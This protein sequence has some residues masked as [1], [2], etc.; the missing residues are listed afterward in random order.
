M[1]KTSANAHT[2]Y[3]GRVF[4]LLTVM[5]LPL[6][7]LTVF[8]ACENEKPVQTDDTS[9]INEAVP[10]TPIYTIVRPDRDNDEEIAAA[11]RLKKALREEYGIE[12]ELTTDWVKRG[13]DIEANRYPHE[14]T[15]GETNRAESIS[16][17]DALKRGTPEMADYSIT[18]NADHYTIAASAGYLDDAV[19]QFLSYIKEN[20]ALLSQEPAVLNDLRIHVFPLSDIIIAGRSVS[21]YQAIVYPDT[22]NSCQTADV[23]AVSDLIFDSCGIRIPVLKNKDAANVG[24]PVIRI[25][26]RSDTEVL[27]AGRFSY[28]LSVTEDGI[29]IDGRDAWG[30]SRGITAFSDMLSDGQIQGGTLSIGTENSIR[31]LNPANDAFLPIAA[32]VISA[33]DMT[34]EEQFAEIKDCGFNMVIL[35]RTGDEDLFHKHCKWL[36]KYELTVLWL[37]YSALVYDSEDPVNGA[38]YIRLDKDNAYLN[39]DIT[40][41]TML[42]DEP[43]ASL[44]GTLK[45]AYDA[46][47][48][49][50]EDKIPYINLFPSYATNEQL[51]SPSYEDH[52]NT[53]LNTVKPAFASVDIYPLNTGGSINGDYFYNLDVF[54]TACRTRGIPFSVYIQSVSFAS[55]KRTPDE[56][57]MLWQAYCALSFGAS[58]IEYFTYRTPNSSTEDF[59]DALISRENEKTEGWYGAQNVNRTLNLMADAY[60]QYTNLG[61]FTV[62]ASG[63]GAYMQFSNQYTDFD[64]VSDVTVSR[65]KP[66]LIGAFSS[67]TA[68]HDR[69]FTCVNLGDPG[70]S[71]TPIDVTVALT[72][73]SSATLYYRDT[74]TEL[75]PDENGCITF[76]LEYGEGCFVTLGD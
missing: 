28:S 71:I 6:L 40:W 50:A 49:I 31:H 46:Y 69:A 68:A 61:A 39:T 3:F 13:E 74:V 45:E 48:A 16:A 8:T 72:E 10:G 32:W 12:I 15:I 21:S 42:R 30:D 75:K 2:P 26:A 57:E 70:Y 66:V 24:T 63:E 17:Y 9:E 41:G 62:N 76:T 20:P 5:L 4:R 35:Q 60:M 64:A 38:E 7:L 67:D 29:A 34:T 55:S 25:G 53:F 18:S 27:E 59:K 22:Y 54:S 44:F 36:A 14:I 43:N 51:G 65:D 47:A 11:L 1:Q 23:S 19:T 33:P 56:R 58:G 37:D 73:A 52:V